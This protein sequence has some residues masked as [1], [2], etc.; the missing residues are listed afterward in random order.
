MF[1]HLVKLLRFAC[2]SMLLAG[3][4]PSMHGQAAP[5]ATQGLEL[6]AFGAGT[7]TWT[8]L[9]G[10]RNLGITA[11]ADLAFKS[12]YHLRPAAEVRGTYPVY[13]GT[14]DSQRDIL[15]GLR[16][17]YPLGRVH[18]YGDFLLGRGQINYERRGFLV[19]NLL[20]IRSISTVFS[21]GVG[22]DLDLTQ[23]W[24][25]KV[26]LQYQ[27][28]DIPFPPGT[29]HPKVLSLGAEYH[30]DFNHHYRSPRRR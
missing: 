12:F 23:H 16:V 1:S 25:G 29:L 19:G 15:G 13:G 9:A 5:T 20:F 17:E 27:S 11:G 26:D 24:S 2:V 18:P 28:W 4:V 10:G 6:T 7:G 22:V 14:I 21:P 30:F 8:N 3:A